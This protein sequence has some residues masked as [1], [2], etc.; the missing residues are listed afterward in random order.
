MN[1]CPYCGAHKISSQAKLSDTFECDTTIYRD[2]DVI[3]TNV[4]INTQLGKQANKI[5]TL[6]QQVLELT[7]KTEQLE[8]RIEGLQGEIH[9]LIT[10]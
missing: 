7:S 2:G 4:C 8:A 10:K 6:Q 3:R 5:E 9:N 1:L